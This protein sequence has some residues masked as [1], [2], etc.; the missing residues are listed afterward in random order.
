MILQKIF[1]ADMNC[2]RHC[3]ERA[4]HSSKD[5]PTIMPPSLSSS[6]SN[7]AL[8][9]LG[10]CGLPF[11]PLSYSD[12]LT[13]LYN[14]FSTG[15][16]APACAKHGPKLSLQRHSEEC[17]THKYENFLHAYIRRGC[18]DDSQFVK[19]YF[20]RT[21]HRIYQASNYFREVFREVFREIFWEMFI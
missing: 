6:L 11:W 5:L 4:R 9:T 21:D 16:I 14:V 10:F 1:S 19:K 20:A 17:L 3:I 12:A 2:R 15:K 7:L 18:S 8:Y 13:T